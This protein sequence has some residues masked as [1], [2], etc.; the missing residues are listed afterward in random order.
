MKINNYTE[1]KTCA[2]LLNDLPKGEILY[3]KTGF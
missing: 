3:E 2:I 1:C